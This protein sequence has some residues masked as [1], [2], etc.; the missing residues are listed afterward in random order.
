MVSRRRTAHRGRSADGSLID[1]DLTAASPPPSPMERATSALQAAEA[2]LKANPEDLNAR[3]GRASAH[4][5]LGESQ[6]AIDD[7]NA[8]IKKAPQQTEAYQYRA[9]AHARLGHKDQ[10]MADLDKFQTGNASE[11]QTL[12]GGGRGSGTGRRERQG[13]REAGR[14]PQNEPQDFGLHYDAA[15]AY[16]L[17]SQAV[18]R[19]T[20]PKSKLTRGASPSPAPRGDP[21]RLHRL[22]AHAGGRR[23]RA[24]PRP[25]S[26]RRDHEARASGPLLRRR[27]ERRSSIRGVPERRGRSRTHTSSGAGTWRRRATAWSPSRSPGLPPRDHRSPLRSGIAR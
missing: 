14:R 12:P 23:P 15:C 25:P 6:K 10:A 17:A 7:L 3:F 18:A 8:V 9:I 5:Q 21:E 2:T 19:R 16:A 27:L 11:S 13:V 1:L 20:L 26:V 24:H 22:Q 4:F